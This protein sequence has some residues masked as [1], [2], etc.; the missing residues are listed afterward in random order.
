VRARED[1]ARRTESG[2]PEARSSS[3]WEEA[4]DRQSLTDLPLPDSRPARRAVHRYVEADALDRLCDGRPV[5]AKIDLQVA[6]ADQDFG[7]VSRMSFELRVER[8]AQG[9]GEQA[10]PGDEQRHRNRRRDELP[11]IA[12]ISSFCA[13]LSMLPQ[14]T[15]STPTPKPR[16]LSTTPI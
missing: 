1:C 15:V 4:Q 7:A 6:Y 5:E 3:P 12:R 11:P 2:C 14:D 10:E 8:V 13:S 9:I 16:K